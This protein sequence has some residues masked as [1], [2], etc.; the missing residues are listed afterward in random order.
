MGLLF[1]VRDG[2]CEMG[3]LNAEIWVG[4]VGLVGGY[5][6]R[7][8]FLMLLW[9]ELKMGDGLVALVKAMARKS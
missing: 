7:R 5:L 4:G 3:I 8:L 6:F 9:L 1:W 2:F